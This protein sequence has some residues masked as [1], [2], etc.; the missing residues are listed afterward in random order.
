M[1]GADLIR[2]E[3]ERQ[4]KDEGWTAD[5]DSQHTDGELALAAVAY[6]LAGEE[7]S[8]CGFYNATYFWPWKYDLWKPKDRL[9]NLV[10]AG[11]LIAAEIDRILEDKGGEK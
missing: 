10:R 8:S 9:Q 3:R 4:I 1:S 2:I 5:Y 6:I 11:A 7:N